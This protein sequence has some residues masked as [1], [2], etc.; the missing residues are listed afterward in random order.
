MSDKN[1]YKGVNTICTHV[2]QVKDEQFGG[3]VSPIYP[4]TLNM[5]SS[6]AC[7]EQHSDGGAGNRQQG[8]TLQCDRALGHFAE[9]L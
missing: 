7:C 6:V 9:A 1:I 2:G 4:G 3:S 8:A 5:N